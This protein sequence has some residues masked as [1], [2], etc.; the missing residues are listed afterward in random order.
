M[1]PLKHLWPGILEY[2]L[3]IHEVH[4]QPNRNVHRRDKFITVRTQLDIWTLLVTSVASN[5]T[6]T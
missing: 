4:S 5:F 1:F 6:Q 2:T 3:I